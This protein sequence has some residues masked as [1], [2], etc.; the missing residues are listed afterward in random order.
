MTACMLCSGRCQQDAARFLAT[1]QQ[2]G[3]IHRRADGIRHMRRTHCSQ[4]GTKHAS[5][6]SGHIAGELAAAATAAAAV[7][8]AVAP[9]EASSQ[10]GLQHV[11][12]GPQGGR[13]PRGGRGDG[14]RGGRRGAAGLAL[15]SLDL[16][17]PGQCLQL[18]AE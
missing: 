13:A 5:H 14:P 1:P 15:L 12:P 7:A 2:Q 10:E 9:P 18:T 8:A 4:Q 3:Q 16:W 11:T 6:P 17:L